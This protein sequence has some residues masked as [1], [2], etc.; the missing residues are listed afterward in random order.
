M[1]TTFNARRFAISSSTASFFLVTFLALAPRSA[2]APPAGATAEPKPYTLF[3]GA[4]FD[5]GQR[6]TYYRVIDVSGSAFVIKVNGDLVRIPTE[7]E[8]VNL[9]IQQSL[10]LTEAFATVGNLKSDRAYTPANDPRRKWATTGSSPGDVGRAA[11]S[12]VS[13]QVAGNNV[14]AS[15]QSSGAPAGVISAAQ[16]DANARNNQALQGFEQAAF[17]SDSD[18][19]N[20]GVNTAKM[21]EDLAK[22]L[23]DAVEVTFEV[24]SETPINEPYVVLVAQYHERSSPLGTARNWIYAKAL[25]PIDNKPR[26]VRILQGGFPAGFELEKLQIHFYNHGEELATNAADKRV[27]LTR[28]EAF[29]Y[30]MIDYV[31][32]HKG[33][34]VPATPAMSKLPADFRTRLQGGQFSQTFFVKVGKDGLPVDAFVDQSCL[35]K[36]EDPYLQT[37]IKDIRFKPAL[38]NGQPVDG[39]ALLKFSDLRL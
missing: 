18:M 31:T 39:V 10:K 15:L 11:N 6:D 5:I 17:Q 23:F 19:N 20:A 29:Q 35:Q 30:I 1:K 24:S 14:V 8:K 27:P 34:N 4:D 2:A 38:E 21:E 16:A 36:V 37:V 33:A 9:K 3:M 13:A 7:R 28:D 12:M 25:E 22:G 32:S 26:K